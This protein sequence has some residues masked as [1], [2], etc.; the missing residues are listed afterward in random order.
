[1]IGHFLFSPG[2]SAEVVSPRGSETTAAVPV[3][4]TSS[5]DLGFTSIWKAMTNN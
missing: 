1:M 3:V 4:T 2:G 5:H